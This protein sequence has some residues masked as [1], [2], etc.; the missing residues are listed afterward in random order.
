M[1]HG[2]SAWIKPTVE[3]HQCQLN[4][5]INSTNHQLNQ[6]INSTM[7]CVSRSDIR[8]YN[9]VQIINLSAS[10]HE[11]VCQGLDKLDMTTRVHTFCACMQSTPCQ[12]SPPYPCTR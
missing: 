1:D 11:H 5:I 6:N 9:F 8:R 10:Q 4:Q 7:Q 12:S 2:K 3:T